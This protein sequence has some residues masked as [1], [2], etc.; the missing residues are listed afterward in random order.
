MVNYRCRGNT[1][2]LLAVS[3]QRMAQQIRSTGFAPTAAIPTARTAS[4]TISP[5]F[6]L[7]RLPFLIR[8]PAHHFPSGHCSLSINTL[9]RTKQPHSAHLSINPISADLGNPFTARVKCSHPLHIAKRSAAI[10][11]GDLSK[12]DATYAS[13]T[14]PCAAVVSQP[15]AQLLQP[16]YGTPYINNRRKKAP[17]INQAQNTENKPSCAETTKAPYLGALCHSKTQNVSPIRRNV[18]NIH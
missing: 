5:A 3:A 6:G 7:R 12:P 4:F 17:D 8:H 2:L 9:A 16:I 14:A 11:S 18:P 13:P 1:S 10:S 15:L